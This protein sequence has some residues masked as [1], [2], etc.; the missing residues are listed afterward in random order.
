VRSALP[1]GLLAAAL[2]LPA[3]PRGA[4]TAPVVRLD[5]GAVDAAASVTSKALALAPP[6]HPARWTPAASAR[7]ARAAFALEVGDLTVAL[8]V[9]AVPVLPGDSVVVARSGAGGELVAAAGG[10][11]LIPAGESRWTW[12][13]PAEPGLHPLRVVSAEAHD[14][15]DITFMV[16]HPAGHV[17]DGS[18]HGYAIGR[19]R[20]RPASMSAAYEPPEGFVEVGAGD[21]DVLV[22]PNFRL[23]Q[24]LCKQQGERKFVVVSPALVVELETLLAA[25]NEAGYPARGLTVMSGFRTPAYNRA[26][27]NTTD[28]SRHLWG[29]AADVYVDDDGN[30]S[31]DDLDRNGRA[32]TADARWLA[33]V[34]ER[35]MASADAVTGGLSVYGPTAAH[36]PFVHVDAR[37]DLS[38]W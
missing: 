16:A 5:D 12:V 28:F 4:D 1:G 10:G 14:T 13:A 29:D 18:L 25:V 26:I 30:G 3:V 6:V 8:R 11:V 32:D 38:R 19:Y 31:M 21:L 15:I 34:A 35:M 37:G 22:S 23:G 36:G 27:G 20:P 33:G 17:R 7:P 24:F 9:M 2:L